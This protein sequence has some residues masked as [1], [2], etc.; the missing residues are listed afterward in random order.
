MKFIG[1]HVS[2]QGGV[3]NAPIN[4][5][6]IGATAFAMFTKNQRQ[7][8]APPYTDKT[9]A[10][11]RENLEKEG[12]A[13]NQVLPHDSYLINLGNPDPAKRKKSLDAFTDELT[14]CQQLGL[15]LL[16]M[17]PG[18]HLREISEE[19]CLTLI[20]ESINRALEATEGVTVVLENTAGQGSNMGYRFEHL[21]AI[22]DQV[23]DKS[24]MGVCIDTCHSFSAGYDLRTEESCRATFQEL[25]DI[26]GFAYL[27]GMHINDSKVPY[28]SRKDRHHSIGMGT[29]PMVAFEFIMK[30]ARFDNIPLI[31]ETIDDTLW[32]EE[33]KRLQEMAGA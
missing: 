6:A 24:R 17:H 12:F 23:D 13:P 7:W 33:I 10:S 22:I 5:K 29:I 15:T 18:S 30:D 8:V 26:V 21:A 4:A 27:R 3:F 11:F 19:A 2:T 31:L 25:E 14:R 16:N 32:P 20:S 1:A 9:I 28:E